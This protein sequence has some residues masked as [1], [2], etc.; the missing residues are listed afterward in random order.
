MIVVRSLVLLTFLATL[1]L[2]SASAQAVDLIETAR[3]QLDELNVGA[4]IVG[5]RSALEQREELNRQQLARAYVLLG[6]AEVMRSR[7]SAAQ[8]AFREALWLDPEL[9][10]DSLMHLSSGLRETFATEKTRWSSILRVTSEPTGAQIL[11]GSRALGST[12][13]ER[14][15]PADTLLHLEATRNGGRKAIDLLVPSRSIVSVHIDLPA[16]TLPW[17][18]VPSEEEL[19]RTFLPASQTEWQ[20]STPPPIAVPREPRAPRLWTVVGAML[21]LV[22]GVALANAY[23]CLA[24]CNPKYEVDSEALWAARI[25]IGGLGFVLGAGGGAIIDAVRR[26]RAH[27]RYQNYESE[28]EILERERRVWIDERV[29]AAR[30]EAEAATEPERQ[31]VIKHNAA[32]RASNALLPEPR[33]TIERLPGR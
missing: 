21:G 23:N 31:R 3:R 25:A 26:S 29:R 17:P 22:G 12:P 6:I 11:V 30:A 20:P 2:A 9:R 19:R 27:R 10:L 32:V 4:A 5:L 15:I 24:P 16:D 33:V 7:G 14:R 8:A 28:L 18:I 13:L 1:P